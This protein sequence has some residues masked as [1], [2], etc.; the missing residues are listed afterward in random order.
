[1]N[2]Q[3]TANQISKQENGLV[4]TY[5]ELDGS[6]HYPCDTSERRGSYWTVSKEDCR[7]EENSQE[8][9]PLEQCVRRGL[10]A[11]NVGARA[12][13]GLLDIAIHQIKPVSQSSL[14]TNRW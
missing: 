8:R 5:Q 13:A 1:M 4:I 6:W 7:S 3:L 12:K 9:A 11:G 2:G 14:E 10:D